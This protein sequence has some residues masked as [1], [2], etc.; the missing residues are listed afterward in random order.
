MQKFAKMGKVK[1]GEGSWNAGLDVIKEY[2]QS[3]GLDVNQWV[4][5]DA[6]GMSHANKVSSS[7]LSQLLYHVR[8]EPW[9]DKLLKGLPVSGG[10]ERF[11]GGTLR[12]R[13]KTAPV[14][15]NVIAKTGSLDNVSALAGYAKT[16][17]GE[18]LIFTIQ[19]Q[20]TK[21]ST[22][23]VIDRMATAI[24]NSKRTP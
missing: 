4:F 12:L 10:Y 24:T 3:I 7:Q 5:E 6:S 15:G 20:N 1:R 2:A 8:S 17:D 9:Y 21:S 22:V 23:P 13:M 16:K 18:W 11:V 14:K 19:T